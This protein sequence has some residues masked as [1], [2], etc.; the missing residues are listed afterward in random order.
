LVGCPRADVSGYLTFSRDL[1]RRLREPGV[2][3]GLLTAQDS[4]SFLQLLG[5][6][7]KVTAAGPA[8]S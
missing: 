5:L 3:A 4:A 2:R 7:E 8:A 1:L 6:G